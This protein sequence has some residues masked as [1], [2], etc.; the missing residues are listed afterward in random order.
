MYLFLNTLFPC[1]F[2]Q[3]EELLYTKEVKLDL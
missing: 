2:H 3:Y 1:F